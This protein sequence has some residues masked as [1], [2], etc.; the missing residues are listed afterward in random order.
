M[1]TLY[2]CKQFKQIR[3]KLLEKFFSHFFCYFVEAILKEAKSGDH[4]LVMSNG[5][6]NGIHQT[7]LN[8]IV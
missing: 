4:I 8:G 5:S 3:K 2:N 6:F 1:K 7:L